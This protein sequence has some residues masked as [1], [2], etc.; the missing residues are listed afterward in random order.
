MLQSWVRWRVGRAL[1]LVPSLLWESVLRGGPDICFVC[2]CWSGKKK[3]HKHI[4]I[5]IYTYTFAFRPLCGLRFLAETTF[6]ALFGG[7]R[8]RFKGN[9]K[10]MFGTFWSPF[11][12]GRFHYKTGDLLTFLAKM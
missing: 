7:K 2:G 12:L 11:F 4:Y 5:Y 3:A 9:K 8:R 1:L 10:C 6:F